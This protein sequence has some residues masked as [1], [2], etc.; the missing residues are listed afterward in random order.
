[1]RNITRSNNMLEMLYILNE[2]HKVTSFVI[3]QDD[4]VGRRR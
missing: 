3:T 4:Y 2:D 1:M